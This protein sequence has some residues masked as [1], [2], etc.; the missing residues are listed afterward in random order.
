MTVNDIESICKLTVELTRLRQAECKH[1]CI[2]NFAPQLFGKLIREFSDAEHGSRLEIT[3]DTWPRCPGCGER[4]YLNHECTSTR[5]AQETGLGPNGECP[6][7]GGLPGECKPGCQDG[8]E[9]L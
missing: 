8:S 1:L 5:P 9:I 7:C 2:E 3:G 6:N 4:I